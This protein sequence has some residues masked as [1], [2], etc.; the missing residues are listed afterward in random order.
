MGGRPLWESRLKIGNKNAN[1]E[2]CGEALDHHNW[3]GKIIEIAS[4][5]TG[6][7]LIYIWNMRERTKGGEPNERERERERARLYWNARKEHTSRDQKKWCHLFTDLFTVFIYSPM[8]FLFIFF[9]LFPFGVSII[10]LLKVLGH[11]EFWKFS[12]VC[13]VCYLHFSK[14]HLLMVVVFILKFLVFIVVNCI[15]L[16]HYG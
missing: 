15:N 4:G 16:F 3:K 6:Y 8:D 7:E 2:N 1:R 13:H 14:C 5:V 10:F 12:F 9:A 11:F